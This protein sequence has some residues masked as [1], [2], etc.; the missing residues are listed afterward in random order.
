LV[1]RWD[2][3]S[4][5][6]A[7]GDAIVTKRVLLVSDDPKF[8]ELPDHTFQSRG[9][10]VFTAMSGGQALAFLS[11]HGADLVLW[12]GVPTDV[13]ADNVKQ[14][15]DATP[16]VVVVLDG[17]DSAGWSGVE[18]VQVVNTPIEGKSLLKLT[19]KVL[20]IPDRK[21]IS[22]LV[23]VRVTQP[24]ATTIFGKSR[25]LSEGGIMVETNQ[26]LV[27]HDQ[28]VVSFLIP[29]ADRMIQTEALVTRETAKA[30]GGRRYGL[31]FLGLQDE[32]S[33]I[34]ADFVRGQLEA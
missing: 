3:L 18:G 19:S 7:H 4:E 31:K 17:E 30:G 2:H 6:S 29:G 5:D 14:A 13:S 9:C 26:T 25:D 27:V 34:V 10:E 8:F 28:V 16:L 32:D 24:K 11:E 1:D 21:Y 20:G 33:S 22:I 15:G 23:Q 12:R